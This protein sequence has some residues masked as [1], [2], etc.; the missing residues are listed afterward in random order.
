MDELKVVKNFRKLQPLLTNEKLK[1]SVRLLAIFGHNGSDIIFATTNDNVYGFG[2]NRFGCLGLSTWDEDIDKPQLNITLSSKQ[3]KNIYYGFGH[4][5]GLTNSGQ[6]YSW[7]ENEF[8]QLGIG[9]YETTNTPQ[10][11][12]QLTHETIVDISCGNRHTLALTRNGRVYGWGRQTFGQ[13]GDGTVCWRPFPVL[14][15]IC[16]VIVSLS[17]GKCH[18]LGLSITGNVYVWG[19]NDFGQ[20]GRHRD[21]DT[22]KFSDGRQKE[23]AF[24]PYPQL[25]PGIDSIVVQKAMCGPNHTLLLS[26]DGDIYA[27]GLNDFGQVGNGT[28]HT[29]YTPIKINSD[30]KFNDI[31]T[32]FDHTLSVAISTDG[33]HWAWGY[34]Y[35]GS[36]ITA[37]QDLTKFTIGYSLPEI[38]AKYSGIFKTYKTI[39]FNESPDIIKIDPL[40][41]NIVMANKKQ[42]V[43]QNDCSANTS[44]METLAMPVNNNNNNNNSY[45]IPESAFLK[46]II[47]F[48][49]NQSD[50]DLVFVFKEEVIYCHKTILEIRNKRFMKSMQ[51]YLTN[52][53]EIHVENRYSYETMFAFIRYL[54]SMTPDIN[55][56][57][58]DQLLNLCNAFGERELKSLC[59]KIL[60]S[61]IDLETICLIYEMTVNHNL[62][63]LQ[64]QCL[65]FAVK[66]WK[67]PLTSFIIFNNTKRKDILT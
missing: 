62:L 1:N 65:D 16:E 66:N 5:I 55:L 32:N 17:C 25:I 51:Q 58:C 4:C 43:Q 53:N 63:L 33:R 26:T 6:C 60:E 59:A 67:I 54:Y 23:R 30:I 12:Q 44:N 29:Q 38:Y 42:T 19:L 34:T 37:P 41:K 2:S 11:I 28:F 24:N 21:N 40:M 14:V 31:V 48:F 39:I 27:C 45:N 18:S 56:D 10:L 36:K 52:K 8:G 47:Q 49:D 9:T 3:L 46:R 57:I 15:S 64:K 20:L 13:V 35:F 50:F 7:G 61:L 22:Q